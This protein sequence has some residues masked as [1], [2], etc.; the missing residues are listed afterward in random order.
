MVQTFRD[1]KEQLFV[2][3][4]RKQK[5]QQYCKI[6]LFKSVVENFEIKECNV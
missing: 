1:F 3:V 5:L 4:A 6:R 2:S